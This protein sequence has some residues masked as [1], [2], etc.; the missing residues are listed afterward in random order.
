MTAEEEPFLP[1]D[2]C[3]LY[4][5]NRHAR[6]FLPLLLAKLFLFALFSATL[7]ANPFAML[8]LHLLLSTAFLVFVCAVRPF[9]SKLTQAR[10]IVTEVLVVALQLPFAIYQ[11]FGMKAVYLQSVESFIIVEAIFLLLA[12]VLFTIAEQYHIW[13]D[14]LS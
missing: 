4:S 12:A 11:Y 9:E 5:A 7:T 2:Y 14:L 13:K 8:L 3:A 6:Y 10:V 1:F